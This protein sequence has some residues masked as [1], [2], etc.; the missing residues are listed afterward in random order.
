MN[1]LGSGEIS[2]EELENYFGE[3]ELGASAI[4]AYLEFIRSKGAVV[5][6][7]KII[8]PN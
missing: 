8:F 2:R 5:K 3:L 6:E 1:R 7:D 4:D